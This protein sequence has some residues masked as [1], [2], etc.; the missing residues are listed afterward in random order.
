[1]PR[2][3]HI[4]DYPLPVAADYKYQT[5]L[6]ISDGSFHQSDGSTWTQVFP[7]GAASDIKAKV[8]I[9]DTT[10]DFLNSKLVVGSGITKTVNSPGANEQLSFAHDSGVLPDAHHAQLHQAA[11]N[12]AGGDAL[13]LDDLAT[14]DDN[15]DLNASATRHGLLS[16]LPGGTTNFLREDGTW[17]PAGG[18]TAR[19]ALEAV[20]SDQ[21]TKS[22]I[23]TAYA[24]IYNAVAV[25]R[26]QTV[27][28]T[29]MATFD[30]ELMWDKVGTGT[31]AFRVIDAD[32]AANV[33]FELA[34]VVDGENDAGGPTALPAWATG[35]KRLKPQ[36]KSTTGTDDPIFFQC[37]IRLKA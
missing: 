37:V 20:W 32:N 35:K 13:K 5:V 19:E 18:G 31:Q 26:P 16:K 15:T 34:N 10:T 28:F 24:D 14:P 9:N 27:D 17:S 1:M 30:A 25:G 8:T 33:L 12:S 2:D 29:G 6:V 22:N 11:H 36:A 7:P 23:G 4:A 3:T 21:I